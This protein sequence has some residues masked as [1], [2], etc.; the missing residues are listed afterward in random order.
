L[1]DAG[2]A[3]EADEDDTRY[4]ERAG[5]HYERRLERDH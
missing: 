4:A 3:G 1:R 5:A 2:R